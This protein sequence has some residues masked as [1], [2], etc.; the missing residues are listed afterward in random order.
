MS[1][2]ANKL[3]IKFV[4]CACNC[5]L[6]HAIGVTGWIE[7]GMGPLNARRL[8]GAPGSFGGWKQS[9]AGRE[10]AKRV[11]AE[12]PEPKDVRFGSIAA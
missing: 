8:T 6:N 5:N 11:L 12:Y 10:S 2:R 4:A 9:G 1:A 3:E 7:Y